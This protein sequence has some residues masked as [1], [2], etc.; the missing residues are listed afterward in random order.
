MKGN[1]MQQILVP[2]T[3]A[4]FALGGVL[5][6]LWIQGIIQ[7]DNTRSTLVNAQSALLQEKRMELCEQLFIA[8]V[9]SDRIIYGVWDTTD[10]NSYTDEEKKGMVAGLI[11]DETFVKKLKELTPLCHLYFSETLLVSLSSYEQAYKDILSTPSHNNGTTGIGQ[12]VDLHNAL[13][14]EIGLEQLT[15]NIKTMFDL[16]AKMPPQQRHTDDYK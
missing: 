14:N 8:L 10:S 16:T 11:Q 3:V 5:I 12:G 15:Q 4:Y 7:K 9:D 6:T 2:L 13:R 1:L